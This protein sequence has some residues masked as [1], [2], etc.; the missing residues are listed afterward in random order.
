MANP[1]KHCTSY[2]F[3]HH[4]VYNN[5]DNTAADIL[6]HTFTH[7]DFCYTTDPCDTPNYSKEHSNLKL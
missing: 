1:K 7:W 5:K 2:L 4:A 6:N 3:A